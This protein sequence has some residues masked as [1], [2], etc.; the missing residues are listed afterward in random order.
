MGLPSAPTL[1]LCGKKHEVSAHSLKAILRFSVC[2]DSPHELPSNQD[3]VG[4]RLFPTPSLGHT[5]RGLGLLRDTPIVFFNIC[6]H[7]A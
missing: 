7:Q 4:H 3:T 6:N 1:V 5:L 2:A